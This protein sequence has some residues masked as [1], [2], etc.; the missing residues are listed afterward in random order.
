MSDLMDETEFAAESGIEAAADAAASQGVEA[1]VDPV[2]PE[3]SA[4]EPAA[5]ASPAWTPEFEQRLSHVVGQTFQQQMNALMEAQQE[6]EPLPD[7]D[8]YAEDFG[9]SL[10]QRLARLEQNITGHV[11]Q[12]LAPLQQQQLAAWAD[13]QVQS[14]AADR[15]EP[16]QALFRDVAPGIAGNDQLLADFAG[17]LAAIEKAAE[18][19][20]AARQL[21]HLK[22]LGTASTEPAANTGAAEISVVRDGED[23]LAFAQRITR[24]V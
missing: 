1:G 9:D 6:P 15:T 22:T 8:P 24:G 3:P 11:Q 18:E 4:A 12:A 23:E 19:R 5:P 17:R 7:L 2:Q 20:G 21:E 16:A 14:L 10:E 13:Q